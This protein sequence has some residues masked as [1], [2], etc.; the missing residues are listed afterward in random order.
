MIKGGKSVYGAAVGILMLEARFPRI[1]GDMGNAGTWGFPVLYKVVRDASPDR[2]VRQGAEGLLDA[3]RSAARELQADGV[4]GITTNC[5]FLSIFQD[6]LSAAVDIPVL[7]SSLMQLGAVNALLPSSRRAGILTVSR[8]SLTEA[9]LAAASVPEGTPIGTTEGRA[10]FTE[11]ILGNSPELDPAAA[12]A[13]NVAAAED[14]VAEHPD[15]GAIVLEC[16]NMTPYAA[17]VR[18]ATGLPV[19]SQVSFVNW[20]QSS[21]SPP[22]WPRRI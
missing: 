4:D 9:H 21:L 3:F 13:D 20:F 7:T 16:T 10:H 14:L 1:L 11:A 5:G 22:D 2:V 15:T 8:S 12:E 17:A 19:F 18:S 6:E